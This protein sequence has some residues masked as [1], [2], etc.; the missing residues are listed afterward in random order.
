MAQVRPH[1]I[2]ERGRRPELGGP[3]PLSRASRTSY[4]L[5]AAHTRIQHPP[6]TETS[7]EHRKRRPTRPRERHL[8]IDPDSVQKV[9]SGE[10]LRSLALKL[11]IERPAEKPLRRL[12]S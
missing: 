4:S 7:R 10:N 9:L 5:R 2:S 8:R 11:Q 1:H 6:T 3:V 12:P